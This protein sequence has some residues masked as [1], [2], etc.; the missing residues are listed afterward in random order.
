MLRVFFEMEID[1]FIIV[2]SIFVFLP[3]LPPLPPLIYTEYVCVCVF[4]EVS[5]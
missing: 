4:R 1:I 2:A 5:K 3:P